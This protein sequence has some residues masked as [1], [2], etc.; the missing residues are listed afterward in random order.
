VAG[1]NIWQRYSADQLPPSIL[2]TLSKVV[3]QDSNSFLPHER[4]QILDMFNDTVAIGYRKNA[5]Q[6]DDR[7]NGTMKLFLST[8]LLKSSKGT[9]KSNF[10]FDKI[11]IDQLEQSGFSPKMQITLVHESTHWRDIVNMEPFV[12]SAKKSEIYRISKLP[13]TDPQFINAQADIIEAEYN[14]YSMEYDVWQRLY[15]RKLVK[16]VS[17]SIWMK[18]HSS[19]WTKYHTVSKHVYALGQ[20]LYSYNEN[21]MRQS[22]IYKK[23]T[24]GSKIILVRAVRMELDSRLNP[25]ANSIAPSWGFSYQ[26]ATNCKLIEAI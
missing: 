5:S 20:S 10:E 25:K 11:L 8:S 16:P 1:A 18:P 19:G 7:E 14:A 24:N 12:F 4:Q 2:D 6:V 22:P 23:L 17:C 3:K 13:V 26:G 21:T 15:E 9:N